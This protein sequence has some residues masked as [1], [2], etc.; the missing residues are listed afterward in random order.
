MTVAPDLSREAFRGEAR[1]LMLALGRRGVEVGHPAALD[2]LS[3]SRGAADWNTMS[4]ALKSREAARPRGASAAASAAPRD[5]GTPA[6]SDIES[7]LSLMR[8]RNLDQ[9][10]I[11]PGCP[12][13]GA[14]D[15]MWEFL[16]GAVPGGLVSLL[17]R[18]T[19]GENAPAL[20]LGGNHVDCVHGTP[21]HPAE[22]ARVRADAERGGAALRV[23]RFART[24][25]DPSDI[26][27]AH[28]SG[29]F[30]SRGGGLNLFGGND[31]SGRTTLMM[32]LVGLHR[33]QDPAAR[34]SD[35][36]SPHEHLWDDDGTARPP[37]SHLMASALG[38]PGMLRLCARR[39]SSVAV[40]G[41][42]LPAVEA[43]ACAR[44]ILETGMTVAATAR[45]LDIPWILARIART[46][47]RSGESARGD[48]TARSTVRA[49]NAVTCQALLPAEG[50][51]R[52][53]A[54]SH[55]VFDDGLRSALADAD[56]RD[57]A[58]IADAALEGKKQ[59]PRG[60]SM[61]TAISELREGRRISAAVFAQA[62][63]QVSAA[64]HA[65]A[66]I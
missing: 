9:V 43:A 49:L 64:E 12:V 18:Q 30:P 23:D 63:E 61:R 52:V 16:C 33:M 22:R 54:R 39:K 24:A 19:W 37:V 40:L 57:W 62:S 50:G 20:V 1:L 28:L 25:P 32:A 8:A 45:G 27:A 38:V 4:A 10:K 29:L 55:L 41:D 2:I 14:R 59:G 13:Q 35:C 17:L 47:P 56:P 11:R 36:S 65:R 34:I 5:A 7:L 53:A 58:A 3:E 6:F 48:E 26:G 66:G 15:G 51:G 31:G 60:K 42:R 44:D 46:L 21:G